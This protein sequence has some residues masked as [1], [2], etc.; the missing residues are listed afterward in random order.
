MNKKIPGPKAKQVINVMKKHAYDSTFMYS[1][2]IS[3]GH[4]C[5]IEDVDGNQFLDFTSNIGACPL[6]Y[7]HPDII[8]TLY[9]YSSNGTYKI[10]GQDFY[11][12]EHANLAENISTI[13]PKGFKTFFINSGAEAVENAI[14]LAYKKMGPLPG[15]SCSIRQLC[16][17]QNLVDISDRNLLVRATIRFDCCE[18]RAF[19]HRSFY[20]SCRHIG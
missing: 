18:N 10:A 5:I 17:R 13:L 2:V 1:L 19:L 20:G 12:Q 16:P 14:K 8:E 3:R 11:C 15:I 9:R 6:G 7:S 4:D